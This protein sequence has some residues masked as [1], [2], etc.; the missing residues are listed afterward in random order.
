MSERRIDGGRTVR[1]FCARKTCGRRA[2]QK[3]F[4]A[5]HGRACR[6]SRADEDTDLWEG[7][8]GVAWSLPDG[9]PK[10]NGMNYCPR[11][12]AKLETQQPKE[13]Q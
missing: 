3:S 10:E 1:A 8:C 12:G 9:T 13:S 4:C 11:C 5:H 7:S 2:A 6:W